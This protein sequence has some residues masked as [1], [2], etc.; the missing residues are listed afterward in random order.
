MSTS[1]LL[2]TE[3]S[4]VCSKPQAGLML[5]FSLS[6]RPPSALKSLLWGKV[7]RREDSSREKSKDSEEN[8][9]PHLVFR[10]SIAKQAPVY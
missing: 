6:S 9:V 8:S 3:N 2:E 5:G 10:V 7:D 1:R 4:T